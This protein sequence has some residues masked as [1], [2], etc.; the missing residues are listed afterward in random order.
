MDPN[1]TEIDS[2]PERAEGRCSHRDR[3]R[4]HGAETAQQRAETD[5]VAEDRDCDR[6]KG[7]RC[8]HAPVYHSEI[9]EIW[10]RR[11]PPIA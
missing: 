6:V 2:C 7:R 10:M 9:R 3:A 4:M 1:E 8:R 11:T 5:P